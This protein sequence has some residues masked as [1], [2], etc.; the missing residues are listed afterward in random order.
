MQHSLDRG[1]AGFTL[2]ETIGA[3]VIAAV[4]LAAA[5]PAVAH[6]LRVREAEAVLKHDLH[7][8]ANVYEEAY[9]SERRYPDALAL[10][11]SPKV[12]LDSQ[13]V[14]GERVYVRLRHV[15]TGQLCVLDYSRSSPVA[16]N[17]ADCF[18]GGQARDTALALT[19]EPPPAPPSDTFAIVPPA[20]PPTPPNP[21][22]LANPSV[23]SSGDQTGAPGAAMTHVYTVTNRSPVPR[24]FRFEAGSSNPAVVSSVTVGSAARVLEPNVPMSIPVS[25]AVAADALADASSVV[26]LRVVDE[27]D[28]RWGAT[29]SFTFST[30]LA[31]ASPSV[32]LVGGGERTLDAGEPFDVTWSLTN[33]TNA[34]RVLLVA[35][36]PS[37]AGHVEVLDAGGAGRVPFAPGQT[38]SITVRLRLSAASDGGT[39][40]TVAVSATDVDAP[41]YRGAA[42]VAV[43]TRTILAAP[44]LTAPAA[45]SADPGTSFT[46]TWLVRNES[47]VARSLLVSPTVEDAAHLDVVTSD[48]AGIQL[49]GRSQALPV[50]VTYRISAGA[51]AGRSS[52]VRLRVTDRASPDLQAAGSAAVTTNLVMA[53]PAITGPPA[54]TAKPDE[55]FDV[56]WSVRNGTNAVRVLTLDPAVAG[57]GELT[58]VSSTGGGEV[59]FQPLE[60]RV[61]GARYRV[62]SNS[63]A[64]ASA[65]PAL[66]VRDKLAPTY[67]ARGSF[68]FTTAADY[69]APALAAPA[70]RSGDP[71]STA[72]GVF[73]LTNRSNLAR[74]FSIVA[75]SGNRAA[76]ADPAD[77]GPVTVPA[78]ATV[79]VPTTASIPAGAYGFSQGA[80]VL[81]AADASAPAY[82]STAQ[83]SLSVNAVYLAPA[84]TWRQAR[85]VRPGA[86]VTDSA[87]LV[88]RSNVPVQFCFAATVGAGTVA[89]G[90]V[91]TRPAVPVCRTLGPAGSA[92]GTSTVAVAAATSPDALAGWSNVLALTAVQGSPVPLSVTAD[93]PVTAEQVLAPPAWIGLPTSPMFWDAGEERTLT[94]TFRNTSN[95]ERSFC[96]AISSAEPG[97]VALVTASP[98]CGI[99][100]GARDTVRVAHALRAAAPGTGLRVGAAVYD[101]SAPELRADS[102]FYNVI[103]ET[104]PTAVWDA[105]APVFVRKW[106]TFDGSR[107]WS[108]VGSP[109]VRYIWTWGLFMQR[110]DPAQGRFVYDPTWGTA[111]DEVASAVVQRAY[112]LQGTFQVCLTVVDAAG[113]TSDPNCQ[114]ITTLRP[115]VARLAWRYR[116]WWSDRDWC[117][118]VWWDNQCDPEHG[119]ARWEVDLRPSLGDVAIKQA[120][121]VFTVNLHNTD[122]PDRPATVTYAGNSGTTPRWGSYT[123]GQNHPEAVGKAQDG[124]WRVLSTAGTA[125]FGWPAA[126]DLANHPLVLNINL[127]DATGIADSGPHWVP[128]DVWITLYVQDEHDRWTSASAYRNHDKGAWRRAYDT[129]MV[130]GS[131]PTAD[132]SLELQESG[133]YLARGSGDSPDGRIVDS[134]WELTYED[135]TSGGRGATWTTR[136]ATLEVEPARCERITVTFAVKDDRGVVAR[137]TGIVTGDGGRTCFDPGSG[138]T[139]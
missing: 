10:P 114:P 28:D 43:E 96:V 93:L 7:N 64:G 67:A 36:E 104:R 137:G 59:S 12:A 11:L 109:I 131:P 113:R 32:V 80:V 9:L 138:G 29:G 21:L 52:D 54:Q 25:Y 61:V 8:A 57:G 89:P 100:V 63:P 56:S 26:P 98:V 91:L 133:K 78:F 75:S 34:A 3:V 84:L 116:G 128:D 38:R 92:A 125:A 20:G 87:T 132:V 17:R 31:L 123:F 115:T 130:A 81:S 76:V 58:L 49:V 33:R 51:V 44:T 41:A 129:T 2:I 16:R 88:N 111:R 101:E 70:D 82:S 134:W 1:R 120:Y 136:A 135:L 65:A 46:L 4:L 108:P 127:A 119:N 50:T 66:V 19:P 35:I 42:S 60:T 102:A 37:A 45:R 48:G 5:V 68:G 112:D 69:R 13:A 79:D 71:G 18:A 47:N 122:D 118:D 126:P 30:D 99:R 103:R 105:P 117:L 14:R 139:L 95:D 124:R 121:A 94:Y 90:R 23:E 107:S 53:N 22:A 73:R 6:A 83:F 77:P 106:A 39:R 27:E 24:S 15:P 40:S 74:T 97:K 110:W 72:T 62:R 85:L 86:A 55:E